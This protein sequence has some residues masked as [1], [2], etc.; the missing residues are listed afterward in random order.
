MKSLEIMAKLV[1]NDT[2]GRI[3][4]EVI[5][6]EWNSVDVKVV[7][8]IIVD[9]LRDRFDYDEDSMIAFLNSVVKDGE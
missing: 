2:L 8:D 7:I 6:G 5:R 4:T 9:E 1:S 3:Y